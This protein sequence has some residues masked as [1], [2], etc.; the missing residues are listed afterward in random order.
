M[1][2]D[3]DVLTLTSFFFFTKRLHFT[4]FLL[5]T[6]RFSSLLFSSRT[7][8]IALP[9]AKINVRRI[10]IDAIFYKRRTNKFKRLYC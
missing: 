9:G 2:M 4:L 5:L 10:E 3:L 1:S 8:P 7:G 6:T